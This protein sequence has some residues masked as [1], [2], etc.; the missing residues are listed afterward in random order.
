MREIPYQMDYLSILSFHL[1]LLSPLL[2][3]HG[4]EIPPNAVV[5]KWQSHK[6][7][8]VVIFTHFHTS[9]ACCPRSP[10]AM[11]NHTKKPLRKKGESWLGM[12]CMMPV[13]LVDGL[14]NG[15]L[16]FSL[17]TAPS[18]STTCTLEITPERNEA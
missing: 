12:N 17:C 13:M 14:H 1:V 8:I 15:S 18:L 16:H 5:S 3:H 6:F 4:N 9:R 7:V 10:G 11:M 2:T